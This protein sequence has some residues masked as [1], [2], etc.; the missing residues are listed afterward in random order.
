MAQPQD[1]ATARMR[2]VFGGMGGFG[3]G[4]GSIPIPIPTPIPMRGSTATTWASGDVADAI[5]VV[6]LFVGGGL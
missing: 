5:R 6:A 1:S 4:T 2:V 3:C